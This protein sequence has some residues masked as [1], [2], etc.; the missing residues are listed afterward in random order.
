MNTHPFRIDKVLAFVVTWLCVLLTSMPIAAH[1]LHLSACA[2]AHS[3]EL[4]AN[5][6]CSCPQGAGSD[7]STV[8]DDTDPVSQAPPGESRKLPKP[9]KDYPENYI[10]FSAAS[11]S[12]TVNIN[13]ASAEELARVLIGIGP[14][15]ADRIVAFRRSH[16][17]FK[18]VEELQEVRGIGPSIVAKNLHKL[19]L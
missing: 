3:A 19:T 18:T 11:Y 14:A 8:A 7:S 10:A 15:K 5:T 16:G 12:D 4:P 2:K 6:L 17:S 13:Q 9:A 1:D